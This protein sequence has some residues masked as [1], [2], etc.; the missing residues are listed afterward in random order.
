MAGPFRNMSANCWG[1]VELPS[2]RRPINLLPDKVNFV[3][4]VQ[5]YILGA[6]CEASL[7]A[8]PKR[9]SPDTEVGLK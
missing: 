5:I 6:L 1:H 7:K 3:C 9:P 4:P 2:R 8:F